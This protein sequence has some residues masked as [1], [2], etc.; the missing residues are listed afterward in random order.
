M[1]FF[2]RIWIGNKTIAT[3]F[4]FEV[5]KQVFCY[6]IG[7]DINPAFLFAED[8]CFKINLT[9]GLNKEKLRSNK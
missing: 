7:T 6:E 3:R 8:V 1:C 5:I 4:I 9:H 2:K